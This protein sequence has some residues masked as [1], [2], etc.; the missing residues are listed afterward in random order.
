MTTI[1]PPSIDPNSGHRHHTRVPAQ[2]RRQVNVIRVAEVSNRS[3]A[4]EGSLNVAKWTD[5]DMLGCRGFN[6]AGANGPPDHDYGVDVPVLRE[7]IL[8]ILHVKCSRAGLGNE[9]HDRNASQSA[10][11]LKAVASEEV[12]AQAILA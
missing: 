6:H 12:D 7:R 5:E 10:R 11:D 3:V 1:D 9:C 8:K 2:P 4:I